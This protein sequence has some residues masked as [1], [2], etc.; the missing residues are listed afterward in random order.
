[1]VNFLG[2]AVGTLLILA[3]ITPSLIDKKKVKHPPDYQPLI[4]WLLLNLFFATGVLAHGLWPAAAAI[5]AGSV[6][7]T[8]FAIRGAKW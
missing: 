8:V 6:L 7:V 5:L 4:I 3:F 1:L 2:W